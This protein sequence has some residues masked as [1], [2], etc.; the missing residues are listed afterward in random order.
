MVT[1]LISAA[2]IV[3]ALIRGRP[4]FQCGYPEGQRL[5]EDGAYL[6]PRAY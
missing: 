4:L 6:K 1:I 5:L 2:F 3:G